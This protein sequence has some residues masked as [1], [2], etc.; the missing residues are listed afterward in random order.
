M[1][2]SIIILAGCLLAIFSLKAESSMPKI[3]SN[4][5]ATFC[6][7][8]TAATNVKLVGTMLPTGRKIKTP[9][10]IFGSPKAVDMTLINDEWQYT[11][12]TLESNLYNYHFIVEYDE[13]AD[14][15]VLD[16]RNQS[17]MR[18]GDDFEN[19][20]VIGNGIGDYFVE[21]NVP[22]GEVSEVWYNSS[23]SEMPQ[24][25]MMVYL[26]AGYGTT[27]KRYPVL[28]LL[29]GSGGDEEAWLTCGRAAQIMDNLI[30][31][32]QC[33]PMIVVMPNGIATRAAA[34]GKDPNNPNQ[35]AQGMDYETMMGRIERVFVSD[36]VTYIDSHY[37]TIADKN[38]RA[39][40]GLSLGGL[41]TIYISA[42]NPTMFDYVGLF[43]AQATNAMNNDN[44]ARSSELARQWN[45][46]VATLP[47]LCKGKLGSKLSRIAGKVE[48]GD[49]AV[50]AD[51]DNKLQQ[52]F[53]TPP[54]LYY[55]SLGSDDFVKKLNTDFK[56]KL[57]KGGY[58][59][60][61]IET[62]GGHTW[63]NWRRYL[64]DFAPRL[65]NTQNN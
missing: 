17:V 61:Y 37:R 7:A 48:D 27:S 30:A 42:N 32:G 54:I 4:N 9:M 24:R 53:A 50:Y 10:G 49:L 46:A 34:P 25:R 22:H 40:A 62:S 14:T 47:F 1:T 55:I 20:F 3:D 56:K 33:E 8:D 16:K 51:F 5:R 21:K 29:H 19:F 60:T 2:R 23:L 12:E 11:T 38:H 57:D 65:F 36:I 26:P 28:Y 41:Q 58:R 15:I 44:I 6:Y 63:D 18:E 52:Q 43:S 13:D 35:G 31:Q 64:I 45:D 39:I 59:Y